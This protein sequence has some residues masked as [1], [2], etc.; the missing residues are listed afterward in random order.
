[1]PRSG[2]APARSAG[3]EPAACPAPRV[4]APGFPEGWEAGPACHQVPPWIFRRLRRRG[5]GLLRSRTRSEV[6]PRGGRSC[7]T[8]RFDLYFAVPLVCERDR[9][10]REAGVQVPLLSDGCAGSGAVAHLWLRSQGL[11]P[12]TRRPDRGMGEAGA[13]QLQRHLGDADRVEED[14][15]TRVLVRGVVGAAVRPLHSYTSSSDAGTC[16]CR[17]MNSTASPGSSN[18]LRGNR[19]YC[20]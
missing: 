16:T 14:R 8:R 19:P 13:G 20:V 11:Q 9:E 17:A 3:T 18:R 12:R 6:S 4:R 7:P 10:P 15:G 5:N 1:V 2:K